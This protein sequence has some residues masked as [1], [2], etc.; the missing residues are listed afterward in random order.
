MNIKKFDYNLLVIFEAVLKERSVSAAAD[1]VGLTQPAVSAALARLRATIGD[2][3]FVR[4]NRGMEP[5][6]RAQ[7]LSGT[8][9]KSLEDIRQSI[10]Q[11]ARFDPT[12]STKTFTLLLQDVGET[13]FL[14]P[15]LTY[16][17]RNAPRIKFSAPQF[18]SNEHGEALVSGTADLAIG[19]Y[20]HLKTPF[21]H[22]SLFE[23][24]F[25]CLVRVDHPTI[26]K[27]LSVRQF[28]TA[29]HVIVSRRG[30]IV[31]DR[32]LD[33]KKIAINDAVR[34]Q[35]FTAVP[36]IIS[37]TDMIAIMPSKLAS[38]YARTGAF[39]VLS[40]PFEAPTIEICQYWHRRNEHDPGTQWLR[41]TLEQ[42]FTIKKRRK[43]P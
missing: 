9:V 7:A 6:L 5:T 37:Q 22:T 32:L 31:L 28:V 25:S 33:R 30:S 34:V 42:L 39:Q 1:A 20:P 19:Y 26:K 8:I 12:T 17:E 29:K 23:T 18:D 2:P 24:T 10:L 35:H 11:P 4:T 36:T 3:L 21:H 16:T 41:N 13:V 14:P 15:L 38:N 27:R 43:S 40:L